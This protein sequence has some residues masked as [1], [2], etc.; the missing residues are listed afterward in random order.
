MEFFQENSKDVVP[1]L[2]QTYIVILKLGNT[3]EF[4]NK[5][6]ILLIPK[7]SDHSRLGN[8]RPIT[9]PGNIYKILTKV[10]LSSMWYLVVC[11]N[12]NVIMITQIKGV[13]RNFIW[14]GGLEKKAPRLVGPSFVSTLLRGA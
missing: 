8:W 9:L 12:L 11:W 5:G 2:L 10:L 7:S 13:I 3:F 14:G 1:T 6:L 4:M